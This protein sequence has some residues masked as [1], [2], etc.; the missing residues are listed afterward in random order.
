MI[1]VAEA[2][3][4]LGVN[5]QRVYALIADGRL[6]ARRFGR[7]WVIDPADL[8]RPE[9][10]YRPTGYPKGRRRGARRDRAK[11]GE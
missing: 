10:K 11:E 5:R 1:T 6:P 4:R 2:A 7:V 8:E 3:S 9:V